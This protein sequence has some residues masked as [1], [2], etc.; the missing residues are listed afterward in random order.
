MAIFAMVVATLVSVAIVSCK[1]DDQNTLTSK[2]NRSQQSFD[3]RQIEDKV[4]YFNDFKKK[5]SE[6]EG[7]ESFNLDDAAW[8]LACLA[9]LDFC[10]V[11]VKHNDFRFDTLNMQV[12][13]VDNIMLLDEIGA[14]YEQMHSKIE[15]FKKEF[16]Y[17]DQNLYYINVS[18]NSN[19]DAKI[20]LMT[21][22]NT[23]ARG[24][25]DHTWYFDDEWDA[26][27]ICDEYFSFD[28]TYYWNGLG[29]SELERVLN[30]FENHTIGV[31]CYLPTRDHT[32]DYTNTYDPYGTDYCYSNSSR[33][34]AKLYLNPPYPNYVLDLMEM[35]YCLDSYLGLGYDYINDNL[36]A[37]ERPVAWTVTPVSSAQNQ[38]IRRYYH[39]LRV[40]YGQPTSVPV[41]PPVVD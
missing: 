34:F 31:T 18:I 23:N 33:V 26:Q 38:T 19:G 30:L 37:R 25:V 24:L 36:Y 10:N 8:H 12:N 29:A 28:S 20:A 2:G 27:W 13:T 6:T 16:S 17:C 15:Q 41:N 11:N 35:C 3:Y 1:K 21:S 7:D 40:Q 14:A 5:M 9:N 22:I 39:Q 32:F 4:S